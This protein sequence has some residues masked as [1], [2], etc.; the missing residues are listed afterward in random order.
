[1]PRI[2][3]LPDTL[4]PYETHGMQLNWSQGAKEAVATCPWCGREDKFYINAENGMWRCV[5]C[6]E[7]ADKDN[8]KVNKGGNLLFFLRTLWQRS[9]EATAPSEYQQLADN[10]KLTRETMIAWQLAKSLISDRWLVPGLNVDGLMTGLYQYVWNGSR[11]FWLPTPTLGHHLLGMNL[12]EG[13]DKI[14]LLEG[15]WDSAAMW[16]ALSV[17]KDSET[18]FV[19]TGNK[20]AGLLSDFDV[21]GMA[22]CNTFSESWLP[23][24]SGKIVY[25]L[26]QNDHE[27]VSCAKCKRSQSIVTW[28][29][30][31]T[32]PHCQHDEIMP[33]KILPA[34]YAGV[35][36][37]AKLMK[38]YRE[39]PAEIHY[40]KW[41]ED[42][43]DRELESGY[44]V[45]DL[46][47]NA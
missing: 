20:E 8:G 1:M 24:F 44:D 6:N 2:S 7:P 41:G 14:A 37:I 33:T 45:R 30:N 4:R 46:L 27:K 29:A 47:T 21:V 12:H 32:C 19:N 10:R 22:G 5:I 43:W 3:T 17:T 42:G 23:L 39:P 31:G 9:Y 35:Q 15:L 13:R 25:L 11:Y 40:L 36:R 16:E 28:K 18:G 38:Q 34:S 26:G